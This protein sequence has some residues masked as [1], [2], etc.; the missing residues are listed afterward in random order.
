MIIEIFHAEISQQPGMEKSVNAPAGS[1]IFQQFILYTL[2][3]KQLLDHMGFGGS[4]I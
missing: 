1:K 2:V 4:Q 3:L